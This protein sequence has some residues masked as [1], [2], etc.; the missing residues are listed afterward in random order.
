[1]MAKVVPLDQQVPNIRKALNK[2]FAEHIVVTQGKLAKNNPVQTGRMASSWYIGQDQ[3]SREVRPADWQGVEVPEFS[4]V[5]EFDGNWYITNNLPYAERVSL[6]PK[7]AKNAVGGAAWF[8]T[9][10][11]QMPADLRKRIVAYL[12][13]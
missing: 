2:A 10:V 3:P 4:G 6:D 12:P 13:K 1:M 8:T 11:G 5:I 9:I 7:W